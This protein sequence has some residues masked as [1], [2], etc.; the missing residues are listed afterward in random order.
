MREAV[1]ELQVVELLRDSD[2]VQTQRQMGRD[3]RRGR[4]YHA[5]LTEH[6]N[7]IL[8]PIRDGEMTYVLC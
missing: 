1:T 2:T 3:V 7:N 6:S 5:V 4:H 8:T